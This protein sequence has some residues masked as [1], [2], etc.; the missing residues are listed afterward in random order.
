MDLTEINQNKA[1]KTPAYYYDLPL[2]RDTLDKAKKAADRY[3]YHI[4]YAVKANN[5]ERVLREIR[6]VGFGSDCVSG[7]E[8]EHVLKNDFKADAV[9][10]AGVGKTDAEIEYAIDHD[11]FCFNV[12]SVA[13]LEV[14][15]EIARRKDEQV[16]IALRINPNVDAKTHHKITTGREENKFGVFSKNME[17]ALQVIESDSSLK[18]IGLH[19]HIGSQ[20]TDFKVFKELCFRVNAWNNWFL[21]K[22]HDL[23]ILDLGGGFGIDYENPMREPVPDFSSFFGTIATYLAPRENQDVHF[24]LGRSLVANCGNLIAKVLYIKEGVKKNFAVL[25]AGMTEFMRPALY[26]AR[27]AIEKLSDPQ[28]NLRDNQVYD[29]VGPICESSDTFGGN[30]VLPLLKRNDLLV[31]RSAGAYGE[32]LSSQYNLRESY[33]LYYKD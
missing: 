13:E 27:H 29:V 30:Y 21:E 19:F 7:P 16:N 10:F 9:F 25:D 24:E 31:I 3:N 28:A 14:M 33:H 18:L 5:N 26:G 15:G 23:S 12:E 22:G 8:I 2:L 32:V 1:I 20:I 17:K 6:K 4:H 11:I